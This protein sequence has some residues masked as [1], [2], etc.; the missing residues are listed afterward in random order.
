MTR[1]DL[2][3]LADVCVLCNAGF[4]EAHQLAQANKCSPPH[5][6]AV[7]HQLCFLGRRPAEVTRQV[8]E[9]LQECFISL[10]RD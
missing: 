10:I 9:A 1:S 4:S 2:L 6:M 7:L 8:S 3:L 5:V